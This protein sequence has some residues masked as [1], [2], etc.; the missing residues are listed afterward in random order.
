M[1]SSEHMQARPDFFSDIP[2]PRR[3]EGL[4]HSLQRVIVIA[5]AATPCG[6]KSDSAISER[7]QNPGQTGLARFGLARFRCRRVNGIRIPPG[8]YVI[9]NIMIRTRK[10]TPC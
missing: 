10:K 2:D 3:G 4:R 6:A 5:I 9:R 1:L 7:A 8:T